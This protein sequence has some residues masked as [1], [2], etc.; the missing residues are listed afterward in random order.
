MNLEDLKDK[1]VTVMGI[2]LHGGGLGVVKFFAKQGAKVLATDL[3]K[4]KELKESLEKIKDLPVELV[5]GEH[6][7]KDFEETDLVI[8]NPA[9]PEKSEFLEIARKRNIPIDSDIGIFLELCPAPIIGVTGTKGKSTTSS[10]LAH[11]LKKKYHNVILAGNI[12]TS[13]LEKLPEINK[14]SVVV[15]ELSSWQLADAKSHKKSPH[16]SVIT[17][18]FPDHQDRYSSYNEYVEDKKLIFRFQDEKDFLFLNYGEQNLQEMAGEAKS[19]V[20]F[21]SPN[22]DE[23]LM[24]DWPPHLRQAPRIGAYARGE[25]IY[26]GANKEEI[27]ALSDIKIPGRHVLNNALAAISVAKLFDVPSQDIK[28][29][30]AE[31]PGLEGRLQLVAEKRGV[32]YYNDTTATNPDAAIAAISAFEQKEELEPNLILIA[33]GADKDLEFEEMAKKIN[34]SCKAAILLDGTA[35]EKLEQK[36]R[37]NLSSGRKKELIIKK[38]DDINEAVLISRDFSTKGDIVLLSPGAASFGLFRHSYERGEKF[39]EVVKN[40]K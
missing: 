15:L 31:F 8:K 28:S 23:L 25:K 11:L 40:L 9:V 17:N 13:V 6:R 24:E 4:E 19:K 26:F 29:A 27:C 36:I 5:L 35:T 10:I 7:T 32:K 38:T 18:V 33:G 16:V 12:R 39:M 22:G 20:Y 1:K 2:G 30:L 34:Q 3:R 14:D 37:E 21:Y